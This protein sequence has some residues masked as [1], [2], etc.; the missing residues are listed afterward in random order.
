MNPSQWRTFFELSIDV[1]GEGASLHLL[2]PSWCS[3]TTFER[4]NEDAGYWTSG[5][6]MRT[7]HR[8]TH[9]ADGGTWGQPFLYSSLAH[10]VIPA[11]FYWERVEPG[12]F[13][14]GRKSQDIGQLSV[15]LDS[16]NIPHRLTG[17]VLE[18]KL[19]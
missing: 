13:E 15:A 18:I 1:L 7:D 11:N 19:Y 3:W 17:L 12:A 5:L 9:I 14:N 10:I 16:A 6:P 8:E 2:S 4:L